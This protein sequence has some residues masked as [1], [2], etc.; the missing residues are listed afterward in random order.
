MK[1]KVGNVFQIIFLD[2][3]GCYIFCILKGTLTYKCMRDCNLISKLFLWFGSLIL[4]L[5]FVR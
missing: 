4:L 1:T 2:I 5:N 3:A